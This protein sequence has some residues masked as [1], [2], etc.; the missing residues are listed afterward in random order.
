MLRRLGAIAALGLAA[1][2][3]P[4]Q[5]QAAA[6]AHCQLSVTPLAFGQYVPSRSAPADFTATLEL[7]CATAGSTAATVEATIGLIGPGG[8]AGRELGSGGH[9]LRYQLFIDPGR[10]MLWGDGSGGT[11]TQNISLI[12]GPAARM[13]KTF[14]IYGRIL[15]RQSDAAVGHYGDQITVVLNY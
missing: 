5:A 12:V 3:T 1:T 9:R 10:T 8:P 11:R 14:T 7:I 15:A 2:A 6:S 4:S 13:T